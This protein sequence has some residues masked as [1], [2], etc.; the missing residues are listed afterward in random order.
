[1]DS[2]ENDM[3]AANHRLQESIEEPSKKKNV[4]K[5]QLTKPTPQN[6]LVPSIVF[7]YEEI[8][9]IPNSTA[10]EPWLLKK[11]LNCCKFAYQRLKGVYLVPLSIKV[12]VIVKSLNKV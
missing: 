7:F 12:K 10:K 3:E 4:W 9:L 5:T 2:K 11:Y 6:P 8:K 1:M